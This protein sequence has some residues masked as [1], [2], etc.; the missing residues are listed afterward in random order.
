VGARFLRLAAV[1][2]LVALGGAFT[3]A[4]ETDSF[5]STAALWGVGALWGAIVAVGA[6]SGLLLGAA[7]AGILRVRDDGQPH[8][9]WRLTPLP[10][11]VGVVA[12][13]AAGAAATLVARGAL[14]AWL[15]ALGTATALALAVGRVLHRGDVT[16]PRA[17][18]ATTLLRW[19]L[20]GTALPAGVIAAIVG[21]LI[22]TL[23]FG[24]VPVPPGELSRH[25]AATFWAYGLL[26]GTGGALK[27]GRERLGGLVD[28]P[29]PNRDPLPALHVGGGLGVAVLWLGPTLLPTLQPEA[30]VGMKAALGFFVGGGLAWL[31]AL[32]GA[33]VSR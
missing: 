32:R 25:L 28:A 18:R 12:G 2:L 7:R 6:R 9:L 1:W 5:P 27:T 19:T 16:R 10:A 8:L 3:L 13:A 20:L 33:A 31:G 22:A 11:V 4:P 24:D 29:T 26:L 14:S 15:V 21:A 23:R 17:R 30:L